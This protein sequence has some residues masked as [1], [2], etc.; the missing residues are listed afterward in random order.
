MSML[1][2]G[3]AV[4]SRDRR[5][6]TVGAIGIISVVV[7]ARGIPALRRWSDASVASAREVA[8]EAARAA[9]S[10]RGASTLKDTMHARGERFIALAPVLL[11]GSSTAT[12]GA[13]LGSIVS[14]AAAAADAKLGSIQV[15]PKAARRDSSGT[16]PRAFAR[17]SVRASMTADVRG[18]SKVLLALER[19][20]TLLWV[21]ELSV[22]QPEPAGDGSRPEM[23]E[24][25][26][27]VAGLAHL[28]PDRS[29]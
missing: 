18:L 28:R 14:G 7:L 25:E 4:S 11:D 3:L 1:R 9:V 12:A 24:V 17:V 29:Q 2:G 19:G 21:E 26:L 22:T 13:T 6:L 27:V 20:P 5:A 10:V 16:L 8:E 23:L 15:L